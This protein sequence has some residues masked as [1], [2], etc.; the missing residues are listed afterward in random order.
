M[1][2]TPAFW[3]LVGGNALPEHPV[4]ITSGRETSTS[5]TPKAIGHLFMALPS[6]LR[7]DEAVRKVACPGFLSVFCLCLGA[8][9]IRTIC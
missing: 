4:H 1:L 9:K 5:E 2:S 6:R 7:A 3:P 8:V